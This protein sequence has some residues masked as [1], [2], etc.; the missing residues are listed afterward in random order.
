MPA[1]APTRS[2]ARPQLTH[3]NG[4]KA[5][6]CLWVVSSHYIARPR[7]LLS[8]MLERGFVPVCFFVVLSGFLTHY[9]SISKPLHT[10]RQLLNFH[11]ARLG[12]ILPLHYL[13]LALNFVGGWGSPALWANVVSALFLT[14]SWNCYASGGTVDASNAIFYV[15][16]CEYSPINELHWTLSTL[17]FAWLMYPL[18]RPMLAGAHL[19]TRGTLLMSAAVLLLSQ[20]PALLTWTSDAAASVPRFNLL[21]RWPPC[22]LLNFAFGM[23]V[24]QLAHD[25]VV[26]AWRVWP[27]LVDLATA[28]LCLALLLSPLFQF[29]PVLP[30]CSEHREAPFR[31]GTDVFWLSGCNLLFGT[32]LLGGCASSGARSAVIRLANSAVLSDVGLYS[33]NIYLMQEFVAK[34]LLTLQNASAGHCASTWDCMV[35]VTDHMYIGGH[36]GTFDSL[37]WSIYAAILIGLAKTW[38]TCVRADS[39][40]SRSQPRPLNPH[41]AGC[42]VPAPHTN[43]CY[44]GLWRSR[45][46]SGYVSNWRRRHQQK[47]SFELPT[48]Q[49][50]KGGLSMVVTVSAKLSSHAADLWSPRSELLRS[51]CFWF[52]RGRPW[53]WSAAGQKMYTR[54]PRSGFLL[55]LIYYTCTT[56][57]T[58]CLLTM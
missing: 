43:C 52:Q 46:W 22:Q 7:G 18:L 25:E 50:A 55:S 16:Q 38:Y 13:M 29:Q 44:P 58:N 10:K 40:P 12:R 24:G 6:A 57:P 47:S 15:G 33:F 11:A 35:G 49:P 9:S 27:W 54:V 53:S 2:V 42:S 23:S 21:Y 31:C 41:H 17:L 32:M 20:L 3:L 28:A 26:L 36:W 45:G 37:W 51:P 56:V 8:G 5:L 30:G 34:L 4:L 39:H 19:G 48:C 1:P 14:T